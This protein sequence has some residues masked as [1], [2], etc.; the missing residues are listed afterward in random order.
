MTIGITNDHRGVNG[1][2]ILTEY[3]TALG[4]NGKLM[5][6]LFQFDAIATKKLKIKS[7]TNIHALMK[8]LEKDFF[9][10][11]TNTRHLIP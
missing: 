7:F 2:Q 6:N 1:K 3:L 11:M 5:W 4:Y 9:F 8:L 10:G